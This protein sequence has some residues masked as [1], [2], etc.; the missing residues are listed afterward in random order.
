MRILAVD[1]NPTNLYLLETLL[2]AHGDEVVSVS[3]GA[4][5]LL[6]LAAGPFDL[7]ISDILMPGMDG[8]KFCRE[9]K[10]NP[11]TK[12]IPFVFYTATYTED[13][14]REL[15]L[16]LGA[17]RFVL[18]PE[19]PERFLAIIDEV[20]RERETG[21]MRSMEMSLSDD[22]AFLSHYND[23]LVKKLEDKLLQLKDLNT[24]LRTEIAEKNLEALARLQAEAA[25]QLAEERYR[26]TFESAVEGMFRATPQGHLISLNLSLARLLGY[27]SPG[28]VLKI[29]PR[30]RLQTFFPPAEV[31]E[32]LE[33]VSTLGEVRNREMPLT[34]PEGRKAVVLLYLRTIRDAKGE[35]LFYEGSAVDIT[36]LKGVEEA[37]R[38]REAFVDAVVE[39]IP[40]MLFVKDAERLRFVRINKAGENFL[41]IPRGELHGKTDADF[42]PEGEA[43]SFA[44]KDREVLAKGA[45]VDIPEETIHTRT[46]GP[47]ILHTKKIPIPDAEGKPL[48]LLGISEDITERK[49]SEE[50]ILASLREKEVLLRELY[51]R[52]KNNMQVIMSILSLRSRSLKDPRLTAIVRDIRDRIMAM[53]MVHQKLYQSRDLSSID[54]R[55]YVEDLLGFMMESHLLPKKKISAD[56]NIPFLSLSIDTAVPCGLILQ[57]LIANVIAHAFP[58]GRSG[59]IAVRVRRTGDEI[60]IIFADDGV[61]FPEAFDIRTTDHLGLATVADIV[62]HQLQG[63]I[64]FLNHGGAECRIRFR[65][66]AGAGRI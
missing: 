38:E 27:A 62:E 46:R 52:T 13:K 25:S 54:F 39:N 3:T 26:D 22:D 57:E 47:R 10:M 19:A 24:R 2:K 15:A 66:P 61:G 30:A 16:K 21:R 58:G 18:K 33:A 49:Q 59:K 17:S 60:E 31:D 29:E 65:D 11:K 53:A 40:D 50:K 28:A 48:F 55:S 41:G 42:F 1:D 44:A 20:V 64:E 8:F 9:V 36:E 12:D 51:H 4:D 14:D 32:I 23:R 43:R 7:V 37:A 56:I 5:A 35:P 45:L 63:R 6:R 34:L